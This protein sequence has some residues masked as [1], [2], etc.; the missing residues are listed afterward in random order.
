[1]LRQSF[2]TRMIRGKIERLNINI[3]S[4]ATTGGRIKVKIKSVGGRVE[5][6]GCRNNKP[7][8]GDEAGPIYG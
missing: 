4:S 8:I 5:P 3:K 1:M 7:T 6:I 2:V